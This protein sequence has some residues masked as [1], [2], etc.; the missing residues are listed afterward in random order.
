MS[1]TYAVIVAAGTGSRFGGAQPKQYLRLGGSPL[2]RQWVDDPRA[3]PAD[4]EA[5]A[6]ADERAWAREREEYLRY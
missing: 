1:A 6:S 2:L 3:T 5:L 4:L